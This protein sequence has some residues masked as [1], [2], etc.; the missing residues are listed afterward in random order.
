MRLK[1]LKLNVSR[2]SRPG[3]DDA[4]LGSSAVGDNGDDDNEQR[5]WVSPSKLGHGGAAHSSSSSTST[6]SSSSSS[7]PTD[8]QPQELHTHVAVRFEP[9]SSSTSS[10]ELFARGV[11]GGV[12]RPKT[13]AMAVAQTGADTGAAGGAAADVDMGDDDVA[14]AGHAAMRQTMVRA[15]VETLRA[16][17]PHAPEKV[18][19]GL[20][21]LA[22]HMDTTLFKLAP[23]EAEYC[24]RT[25]LRSRI[26][27]I[28]ETNAKR[29]LAQQQQRTPECSSSSSHVVPALKPLAEMQACKVFQH[30]Q[31]WRQ[32]LVHAHAVAPWD[33]LPN[34]TL[35]NVALYMP[36][37]EAELARCGIGTD[38]MTRFGPSLMQE[39]QRLSWS[40]VRASDPLLRAKSSRKS[41]STGKRS[42]PESMAGPSSR[43]KKQKDGPSAR[44]AAS[45]AASEHSRSP[46][47]QTS[48]RS[49]VESPAALLPMVSMRPDGGPP[50]TTSTATASSHCPSSAASSLQ[51]QSPACPALENHMHLLVQGAG[52]LSHQQLKQQQQVKSLEAYEQEVQSLR[53]MLH[54]SQQQ[55]A[56]LERDVQRLRAELHDATRRK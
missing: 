51:Q 44:S 5:K 19:A 46:T 33:I 2:R 50:P 35:A 24:D 43:R 48:M 45:V 14:E 25:T 20:P 56:Q 6:S 23:S 1:K 21:T 13:A 11:A 49:T 52:Q 17:K 41:P 40:H 55:T 34:A 54:Q 42:A 15:I 3:D 28:Q 39:L 18:L 26:A 36:S 7:S 31:S 29:L 38:R 9:H 4:A 53:W 37:S 22:Q 10:S 47:A 32:Q 27:Q 16:L 8:A 30:L 12:V